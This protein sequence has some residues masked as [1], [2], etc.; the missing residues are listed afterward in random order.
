MS[1]KK[2]RILVISDSHGRNDDVAG[3]IEQVGPIDMLIHCGDV[4]RGDDYI[5]SLVDCPVHMVAGNNDYNLEL[6]SQDIFNIGDYKV[7]VVHGHTFCVYRGVER[8][9]QYALQNHIDIVMFGHTHKP[10]IEIDE[11]V[12]VLNPGSVSYP[13]QP[14]HMPT[15]LIMEIDDEGEAHYGHGYYKSKFSEIKI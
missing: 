8:L 4:E 11:D 10:Y 3:V 9:K 7:L 15:F 6:P 12:T 2:M 14:D 1:E 5:R 13:R